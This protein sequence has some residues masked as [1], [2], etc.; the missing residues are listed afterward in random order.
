MDH[1]T[2]LNIEPYLDGRKQKLTSH[3]EE[4]KVTNLPTPSN[5]RAKIVSDLKDEYVAHLEL[6][7]NAL[8]KGNT[9]KAIEYEIWAKALKQAIAIATE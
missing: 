2:K 7:I 1:N 5:V 9:D 3:P 6:I 4:A 8:K